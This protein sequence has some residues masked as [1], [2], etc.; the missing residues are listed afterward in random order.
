MNMKINEKLISEESIRTFFCILKN[1]IDSEPMNGTLREEQFDDLCYLAKIHSVAPILY[2]MLRQEEQ[3]LKVLYPDQ[4]TWLKNQYMFSAVQSIHQDTSKEEMNRAF[5][6]QRI[7]LLFFKGAQIRSFYPVPE[8]RTM[9][10]LDCLIDEKDRMKSHTL[11]LEME[12]ECQSDKGNVWVYKRGTVMI[13]MH[14]QIAGN[15]ISNGFDYAQFFS[16][17]LNQSVEEDQELCLKKEYHFCFL[18]YHIAKHL[19]STG[20]GVRMFMDIAVFLRYYGDT[21]DKVEAERLLKEAS[22]EK[23]AAAVFGLCDR[24]F[25]TSWS[26]G[27]DI[28]KEVLDELEEYILSGGTFGFETHDIGH[29]YKR[30]S[31]EN[32]RAGKTG[33][34]NIKMFFRYFF[35]KRDYVVQFL[36]ITEKY[37]WLLPV[38]WVRRWWIGLFKRRKRSLQTLR[39]MAEND[40]ERSYREYEMLKKIG[41]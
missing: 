3:V 16:D 12:Y 5:K 37:P 30:K 11:M 21:F 27:K 33:R 2:Y 34:S 41:L 9:G 15:S 40:G 19:S 18:I 6:E 36:P 39:T 26:E 32:G 28:S 13:E 38:A 23:T 25:G 8:I 22:L 17:A 20:A 7:P 24:W 35:P 29:V 14:T 4:I 10:D 1:Y 31:C